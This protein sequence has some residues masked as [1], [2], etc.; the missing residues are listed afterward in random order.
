MAIANYTYLKLK[1]PGP[2]GVITVGTSFQHAYKCEVECCQHAST[3]ITSEELTIIKEGTIEEAP[4]SKWSAKPFEPMEGIK[5]ILIDPN[6]SEDK[7]VRIDTK[8]SYK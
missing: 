3:I 1:M 8:L 5:E 7:V 2:C 4:N 6:S